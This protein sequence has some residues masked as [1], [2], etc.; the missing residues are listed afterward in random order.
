MILQ[1]RVWKFG[2]DINTDI[3]IPGRY[4]ELDPQEYKKHIMEPIRPDFYSQI[5]QGDMIF[6]GKSFGIGSSRGQ[7]VVSLLE[8]G[9]RAIVAH[10]FA[11]IFYRSAINEGLP[12]IE[13]PQASDQA[14]EGDWAEIDLS[15]GTIVN[16]TK[17]KEFPFHPFPK[18]VRDIL[19]AGGGIHYYRQKENG[20]KGR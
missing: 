17:K 5:K 3:I 1:G 7:A 12:V 16:K 14:E 4:C 6:A 2:D 8:A 11:R 10:S 18:L 20:S 15:S 9:L 19:L 13:C